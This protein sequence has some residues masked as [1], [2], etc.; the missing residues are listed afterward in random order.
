MRWSLARVVVLVVLVG[1]ATPTA[2]GGVTAQEQTTATVTVVDQAGERV[3][4]VDLRV[5][6]NNGEGSENV[7]T[8]ANGQALVDVPAGATVQIRVTDEEYLRNSPAVF[9]GV[10]GGELE[11]EVSL[12]GTARVTATDS[13]GQVEGATARLSGQGTIRTAD[14]GVGGLAVLGPVERGEYDL[15]VSE[16]GYLTNSTA[17]TLDGAV[18]RTITL[19]E[20]DR[21]LTVR[22][23]DD[24]FDP[25]RTLSEA[26]VEIEGVATL[27]T[28]SNGQRG[29]TVAV[30]TDY[31]MT[32]TKDGYESVTR[33]VSVVESAES[34]TLAVQ[35]EEAISVAVTAQRV[36]LGET[37]ELTVTDEY[38]QPVAG[39]TVS[40]DG[41]ERGQTD[42][43]GTYDL[44]VDSAGNRTVTVS[45]DGLLTSATIEGVEAA[46][47][48][49]PTATA[50]QTD[51]ATPTETAAAGGGSPGFGVTA[52]LA[53]LV[54]LAG[55]VLARARDA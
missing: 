11:V 52:V 2:T 16:P 7:T 10:D 27:T 36:L 18:N 12:P 17:V 51:T 1:V 49:T 26:T 5:V 30:N 23:V 39:A 55:F 34:V 6:W 42:N 24:K 3:G 14:T 25:P 13:A 41:T 31:E 4:D 46:A 20:A 53:A 15:R 21:Q 40:V 35:R 48:E 33:T 44:T 29:T 47:P 45:A 50:T 19:R 32:A 54:A 28:G 43:Q 38:G 8:R 37:T 22:V 9:F